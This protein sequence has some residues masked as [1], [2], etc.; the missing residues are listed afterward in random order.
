MRTT[1]D[2]SNAQPIARPALSE[3]RDQEVDN[4]HA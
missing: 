1:P 2:R 4:D 3:E